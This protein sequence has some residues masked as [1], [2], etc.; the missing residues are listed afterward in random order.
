[1]LAQS[2]IASFAFLVLTSAQTLSSGC[3][4]TLASIAANPDV[5]TCL[6]P[7]PL[8][9][10]FIT[11]GNTSVVTPVNSWLT[12]LCAAASCSNDTLAAITTN[13]TTGCQAEF[14]PLGLTNA[15]QAVPLVQQVYPVV[16]EIVCLTDNNDNGAL[17]VTQ[18]LQNIQ[19][20]TGT[21]TVSVLF[22]WISNGLPDTVYSSNVVCTNCV[23]QTYN[24]INQDAPTFLNS[25]TTST[26]STTCGAS[27]VDGQT[28]SGI[29]ESAS[30]ST[31]PAS[32]SGS[33]ALALNL[34]PSSALGGAS[35]L[36]LFSG[37]FAFLA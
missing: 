34:P 35:A 18:T 37:V 27:F 13:L 20:V 36:V 25:S 31:S 1:M 30:Q 17:C 22:S 6:N 15:S 5:V 24:V 3:I 14:A 10:L 21:I 4:S 16:R 11:G 26:L 8:V 2:V 23:K 12:G 28:P 33:G 9:S 32:G 19:N 29:S 7:S